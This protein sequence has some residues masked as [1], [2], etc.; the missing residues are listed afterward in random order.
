MWGY[1]IKYSDLY[2]TPV[3]DNPIELVLN[4]PKEELIATIV[5]GKI[6]TK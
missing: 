3:P 2:G 6:T 5:A 1:L 4:I